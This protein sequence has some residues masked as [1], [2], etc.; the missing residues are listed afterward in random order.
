MLSWSEAAKLFVDKTGRPGP[1][2]WMQ[3]E[4]PAGQGDYPVTGVSWFEAAAYAEFVGK[5]LPTIYHWSAAASPTDSSSMIPASNFSGT[6][7]SSVGAYRGM[8]WCGAYDMAGNAKEWCSNET[9][10]G[11]HYLMGGAWSDPTY[12]FNDAD[13]REP[14]QRSAAFGFRCAKYALTSEEAKAD[15]PITVQIRNYGLEKPVSDQLFRAYKSMYSYD[16]T[17][18]NAKVE[19]IVETDD[20]K[21]EKITFD[22]AYGGERIIAYLFLPRKVSPP[23]QVV[24]HFPGASAVHMRSSTKSLSVFLEE[25]L[26]SLL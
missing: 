4:Y 5:S 17:P 10:S 19:S 22:S 24:V 6:G 1:A 26:L 3:G 12:M 13:A 21:E 9:S 20:W 25:S 11:K 16:K 23:F 14:F 18:L 2:T 7:P 8:S 15:G